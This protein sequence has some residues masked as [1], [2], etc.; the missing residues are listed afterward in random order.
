MTERIVSKHLVTDGWETWCE[1]EEREEIVRC[2]DCKF[3]TENG[4]DGYFIGFY[5]CERNGEY[6]A[7][8]KFC[9]W[10]EKKK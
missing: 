6:V 1:T 10:A 8:E 5:W 2:H 3:S 9:A 4:C 7:P